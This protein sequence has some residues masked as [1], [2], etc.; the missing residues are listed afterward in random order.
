MVNDVIYTIQV[1]LR[2]MNVETIVGGAGVF[3]TVV[4]A[5]LLAVLLAEL[6]GETRERLSG[7]HPHDD[8]AGDDNARRRIELSEARDGKIEDLNA[9]RNRK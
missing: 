8:S 2:G 4:I 9:R 1:A 5:A 3:D 6:I 7:G